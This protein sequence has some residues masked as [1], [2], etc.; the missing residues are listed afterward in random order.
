MALPAATLVTPEQ[1]LAQERLSLDKHEL[2]NGQVYAMAGASFVHVRIVANLSRHLGNLLSNTTCEPCGN[3]LRVKVPET[4]M[5]TY[6]D[7]T[8]I[9]GEPIFD[10]IQKDTVINPLVIIEVLSPSTSNYDRGGK[11]FHYRKI[12]SLQSYILVDQEYVGIEHFVRQGEQ[13]VLTTYEKRHEVLQIPTLGIELPISNIY[14]RLTVPEG[15]PP[16]QQDPR[17]R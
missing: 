16:L 3:D 15:P 12:E 11:F 17:D 2:V 8:V 5:Y 9:C 13:W 4:V 14:E 7:V 6:P 1:Y 10:D